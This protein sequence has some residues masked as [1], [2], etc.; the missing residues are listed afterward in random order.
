MKWVTGSPLAFQQFSN[1]QP[2]VKYD[3]C[4]STKGKILYYSMD[5]VYTNPCSTGSYQCQDLAEIKALSSLS[6]NSKSKIRNTCYLMLL[7]NLVE[8][9]W[10]SVACD[11]ALLAVITCIKE[12][13]WKNFTN[14]NRKSVGNGQ[15][16]AKSAL[17]VQTKCYEFHWISRN[18][19]SECFKNY[20][21]RNI[22]MFK[23]IFEIIALENTIL[24]A[25]VPK[26]NRTMNAIKFVRYLDTVAFKTSSTSL[27]DSEGYIICP[28]KKS[29][30]HLGT[31][32][33]N[34]F[35]LR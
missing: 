27:H 18:T 20:F 24:S 6:V 19:Y 7:R 5:P 26:A 21:S 12:K 16:C 15:F 33:F 25:F 10:V 3:C 31:H 1:G 14:I 32:I 23:H 29:K 22:F 30:I 4:P 28:S 11:N 35:T 34:C 17:L 13:A 2:P 9:N 8:P